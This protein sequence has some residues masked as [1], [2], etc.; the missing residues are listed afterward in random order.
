MTVK[1]EGP[2]FEPNT[3]TATSGTV[4][5]YLQNVPG[6]GFLPDHTMVIGAT[7]VVFYHDGSVKSGQIL[8]ESRHVLPKEKA[9]FTV[10]GL[11]AGTYIFWCNVQA[12]DVGTHAA[13]GMV[14]TLTI[15]P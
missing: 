9:A 15:T 13:L 10:S 1:S 5:F 11:A 3:L 2:R 7:D 6:G 12:G 4:T 14:G 8:A